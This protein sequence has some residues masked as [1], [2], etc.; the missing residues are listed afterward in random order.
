MTLI[1]DVTETILRLRKIKS[2]DVKLQYLIRSL[3]DIFCHISRTLISRL[4]D[5]DVVDN[6]V[7][8]SN[9]NKFNV[10]TLID[11]YWTVKSNTQSKLNKTALISEQR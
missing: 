8:F 9:L 10:G 11:M 5:L 1:L 6:I 4:D 7:T 3:F 2:F